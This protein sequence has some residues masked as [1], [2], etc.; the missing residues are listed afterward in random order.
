MEGEEGLNK[1]E[2]KLREMD[3]WID[4]YKDYK[5]IKIFDWYPLWYDLLPILVAAYI[6]GWDEEKMKEFGR[7]N[8]KVSFF[9][10]VLLKYF[11]SMEKILQFVPERWR[12]NYSI[13]DFAKREYSESGN[14]AILTLKNF[15]GHPVFCALLQGFCESAAS[16]VVAGKKVTSKEIKCVFRGDSY[17]EF[18]VKWE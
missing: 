1:L 3:C 12:K 5:N 2:N 10:R 13:G 18:F 16:F 7:Y 6:F 4:I 8:Q 17:H 14:Y 15:T 9:E 11:V